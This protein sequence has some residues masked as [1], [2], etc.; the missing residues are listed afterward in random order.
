MSDLDSKAKHILVKR[1]F[2]HRI[3]RGQRPRP[4]IHLPSADEAYALMSKGKCGEIAIVF[5]K[6]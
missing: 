6:K 1:Y 3:F 4:R 5:D 2:K